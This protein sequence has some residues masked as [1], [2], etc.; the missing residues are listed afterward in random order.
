MCFNN[1]FF[2][3]QIYFKTFFKF[4]LLTVFLGVSCKIRQD[5][6]SNGVFER[7][8][9]TTQYRGGKW[10]KE[11][12]AF[13]R[14]VLSASS[15]CG[16]LKLSCVVGTLEASVGHVPQSY[17][18]QRVRKLGYL[19]T[20]TL[21]SLVKG[22][23]WRMVIPHASDLPCTPEWT[24]IRPMGFGMNRQHLLLWHTFYVISE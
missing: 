5:L 7:R 4:V 9:Q 17:P 23:F 24:E 1:F 10:E 15:H 12:A 3:R 11:G 2:W 18:T 13:T 16:Q 14:V 6:G 8:S 20:S 22:C 19:S 21:W